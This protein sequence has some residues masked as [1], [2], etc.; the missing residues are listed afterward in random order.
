M[1]NADLTI[2]QD[3]GAHEF[4]QERLRLGSELVLNL[5]LWSIFQLVGNADLTLGQAQGAH[6]PVSSI[7]VGSDVLSFW[8]LRVCSII[9]FMDFLHEELENVLCS[10]K[11]SCCLQM[12]G[13]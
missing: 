8:K 7:F 1:G 3:Q 6:E 10:L 2:G 5:F 11:H 9:C 4:H 13:V 12:I